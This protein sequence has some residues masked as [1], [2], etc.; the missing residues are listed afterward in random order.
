MKLF[1]FILLS[2]FL[3]HGSSF[4]HMRELPS[5]TLPHKQV[6]YDDG[7]K[8]STDSLALMLE[9]YLG[10]LEYESLETKISECDFLISTCSASEVRSEVALR[11]YNY[12]LQSNL[13]GVEAV[14]V[15]IYDRWFATGKVEVG[16][17]VLFGAKIFA[18]F[19][20]QSLLGNV[21]PKLKMCTA[22][23]D[24]LS[25]MGVADNSR[26]FKILYFYDVNCPKCFVETTKMPVLLKNDF[27]VDFYPIYVGVDKKA[28]EDYRTRFDYQTTR[29]KIVNLWDEN[30]NSDYQ[31]KYGVL[32]T[33]KLFLVDPMG[34][35]IGRGLDVPTLTA[36]LQV[37]FEEKKLEYGSEQSVK[38][39]DE[40]FAPYG[41]SLTAENV[42]FVADYIEET[43][44]NRADTLMFKQLSG[45]LLYYLIPKKGQVW[46]D[47]LQYVIDDK[48]LSRS[49]VWS[50]DDDSLKIVGTAQMMSEL[51]GLSPV[52]SR[53][54]SFKL[55]G[56]LS[57]Q[58]VGCGSNRTG[59][60][61]VKSKTGKFNIRKLSGDKN[62]IFFWTDG[63]ENCKAE[64]K[65]LMDLLSSAEGKGIHL[66][67]VNMDE[68][69]SSCP[70]LVDKLL[71]TFD[72]SA[73]PYIISTD[74]KGRVTGRYLSFTSRNTISN[75]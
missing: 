35:I 69:F 46:K 18:D 41:S 50:S 25:I 29:T 58:S 8:E 36:M 61:R 68:I 62:L 13:M 75:K 67:E 7:R 26:R 33:P 48:V 74:R 55:P 31:R 32:Q 1:V 16:E 39:F 2:F 72:L 19:N 70:N 63:C 59:A 28:W 4:A 21:A 44:L 12:Y 9:N 64:K 17:D 24:S 22:E 37:I 49:D 56:V 15:H 66:F 47:G 3:A 40:T 57:R 38:V 45:D 14:S 5:N 11:I 30:L 73:L 10:V 34:V 60:D 51:L 27:P 42:R 6:Q 52:G 53:L 23:G 54:P 65:A 71:A 43:T 20:R